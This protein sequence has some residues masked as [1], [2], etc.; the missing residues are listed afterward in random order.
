MSA[1]LAGM[2]VAVALLYLFYG[3]CYGRL[4]TRA[5]MRSVDAYIPIWNIVVLLRV[6]GRPWWWLLILLGAHAIVVASPY[7]RSLPSLIATLIELGLGLRVMIDLAHRFGKST[8]YGVVLFVFSP[9]MI[10]VLAFTDSKA[11]G[12]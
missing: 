10:P 4:F 12:Q 11:T 7:A 9:I 3:Y 5:G 1:A 8:S 6:V 2:Y